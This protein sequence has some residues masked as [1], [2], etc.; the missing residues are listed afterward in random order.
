MPELMDS[1]GQSTSSLDAVGGQ[2]QEIEE[3]HSRRVVDVSQLLAFIFPETLERI[4][5]VGGGQSAAECVNYLLD[6]FLERP[7]TDRL[8]HERNVISRAGYQQ[9][10]TG[11]VFDRLCAGIFQPEQRTAQKINTDD[12]SVTNGMSPLYAQVAL[13]AALSLATPCRRPDKARP[14]VYVQANTEVLETR[15]EQASVSVKA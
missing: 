4:L 11:D 10:F 15:E 8:G 6:K 1:A 13:S 12:K 14:T 3:S 5:V 9:L 7:L 2:N